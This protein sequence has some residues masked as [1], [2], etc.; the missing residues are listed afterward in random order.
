[1]QE[2]DNYLDIYQKNYSRIQDCSEAIKKNIEVLLNNRGIK[3][4]DRITGRA[5]TVE[6]F[7]IKAKKKTDDGNYKYKEPLIEIQDQIGV[8]IITYY[9]SDVEKIA[10]TILS[11]YEPIE[12]LDKHPDRYD[13]FSYV[14][15]HFILFIPDEIKTWKK[16]DYMPFFFELQIKTM[17]QHAWAESEHDLNYKTERELSVEDKRLIAFSAAQAWG[18]DNVFERLAEKYLENDT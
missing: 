13:A 2:P 11:N 15:K 3:R 8:R 7:S 12:E 14:G 17:F 5:K 9:L 6:R 16:G 10:K 18:A 4:R 1:M